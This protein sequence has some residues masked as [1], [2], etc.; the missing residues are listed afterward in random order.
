[1]STSELSVVA[2]DY[3]ASVINTVDERERVAGKV[4]GPKGIGL[5]QGGPRSDAQDNKDKNEKRSQGR[6][7]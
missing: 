6:L 3:L 1:M 7:D 4:H 5:R 2:A